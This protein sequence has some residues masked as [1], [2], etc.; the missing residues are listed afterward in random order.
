MDGWC[1][2]W[3]GQVSPSSLDVA[4][5]SAL[6]ISEI[7]VDK[8][9]V[10]IHLPIKRKKKTKW[11]RRNIMAQ[12]ALHFFQFSRLYGLPAKS[13]GETRTHITPKSHP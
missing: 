4:L 3:V 10:K 9:A 5:I 7:V 2:R 11:K 6:N 8:S 12:K 13:C 1:N